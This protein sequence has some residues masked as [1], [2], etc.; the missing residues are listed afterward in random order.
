MEAGRA[1]ERGLRLGHRDNR[2]LRVV[3]ELV[4]AILWLAL[5]VIPAAAALGHLH[6]KGGRWDAE[7]ARKRRAER[8]ERRRRYEREGQIQRTAMGLGGRDSIGGPA[9]RWKD[10]PRLADNDPAVIE[11]KKQMVEIVAR[12]DAEARAAGIL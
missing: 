6:R 10:A 9:M 3:A 8:V 5:L 2:A 12:W 4:M 7:A 11:A 1:L